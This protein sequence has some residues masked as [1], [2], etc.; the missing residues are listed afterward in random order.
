MRP[1]PWLAPGAREWLEERIEPSWTAF[2][3]GSGGSTLWL[4]GLCSSVTSVEHD[5]AWWEMTRSS[6]RKALV[7]LCPPTEAAS[8]PSPADPRYFRSSCV[9]GSFELYVK[10]V[11]V[12]EP[13]LV[14]VDGRA[15]AS[16][17]A[18]AVVRS[19]KLL[20]LDNAERG[21]YLENTIGLLDGWER[22]DFREGDWVT[23]AWTRG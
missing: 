7:L 22:T 17:I 15:R 8:G 21:W 12:A 3:W 20:V 5:E 18:R 11:D 13:D 6:A 2:E 23:S 16:C 14:I 19:P 4:E 10:M 1:V 9:P